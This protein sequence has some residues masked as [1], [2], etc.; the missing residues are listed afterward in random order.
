MT[1]R[2]RSRV[3]QRLS[4]SAYA[5]TIPGGTRVLL[6]LLA[7]LLIVLG[8]AAY[9][10][11]QA[12]PSTLQTQ[13][14]VTRLQQQVE[15]LQHDLK[16]GEMRLQQ[17]LVTRGELAHQMDLQSQKLRQ[18][19]QEVQFFRGQKDKAVRAAVTPR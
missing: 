1:A 9:L 14:E 11:W 13:G 8:A 18:A 19:E 15:R 2:N 6:W 12:P 7:V 4:G 10:L 16:L 5:L 3:T 17:E